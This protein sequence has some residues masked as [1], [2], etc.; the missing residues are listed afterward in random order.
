MSVKNKIIA[1]DFDGTCVAH[2]YPRI[3]RHIGSLRVLRRI[4]D[5][6]GKLIL[7]TMRSGESLQAAVDW[8]AEHDLPLYGVQTNPTQAKWTDSPKAF[9]N[10]CIDDAALGCP[11][12]PGLKGE[13]PFVDWVAVEALLWPDT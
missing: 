10:M 13:R 11:L 12:K 5:D 3:G 8:F 6:G 4:V 7:W 9:A 1:V 2:E